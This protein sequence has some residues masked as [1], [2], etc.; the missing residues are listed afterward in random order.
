M[1]LIL[2]YTALAKV[3]G[4]RTVMVLLVIAAGFGFLVAGLFVPDLATRTVL[5]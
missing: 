1:G 4:R 3:V 2:G 5:A